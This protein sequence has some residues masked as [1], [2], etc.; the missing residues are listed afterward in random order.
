LK[1]ITIKDQIWKELQTKESHITALWTETEDAILLEF[2]NIKNKRDIA[3]VMTKHGF[4]RSPGAVRNR[5]EL[6]RGEGRK[7]KYMELPTYQH[8]RT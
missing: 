3:E 7:F 8:G 2:Y 1:D 4:R 6:L 5:A